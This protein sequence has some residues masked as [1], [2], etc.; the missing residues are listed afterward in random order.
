MVQDHAQVLEHLTRLVGEVLRQAF[1]LVV[2][3]D[4]ARSVERAIHQNGVAKRHPLSVRRA[5][6]VLPAG[7]RHDYL[8]E[9]GA[10]CGLAIFTAII[11]TSTCP[12]RTKPATCTVLRAGGST[13]KYRL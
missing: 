1:S 11:S 3:S 4:R 8:P 7:L 9:A 10:T 5:F 2:P 12:P 6:E 13:L